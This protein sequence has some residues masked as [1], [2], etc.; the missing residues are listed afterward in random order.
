MNIAHL[1]IGFAPFLPMIWII[2]LAILALGICFYYWRKNGRAP[3]LRLLFFII[4]L[5]T[6]SNPSQNQQITN[7]EPDVVAI[8]VD[9]SSSMQSSAR[10]NGT[11]IALMLLENE[12]GKI[13]NVIIRKT[14]ISDSDDGTRINEAIN[15]A[16]SGFPKDRIAGVIYVGDGLILDNAEIARDYPIHQILIGE[17]QEKDRYIILTN[18]PPAADVGSEAEITF[19]VIENQPID[20]TA[21][22]RVKIGMEDFA[23]IDA[24]INQETKIKIPITSR[25][26]IP[27][28]FELSAL[29]GEISKDNNIITTQIEGTQNRL[30]VLLVTGSPYEGARAWRN[31]LKSDPNVD[32]VHFTILRNSQSE[33]VGSVDELSLIPFPTD[34]LFLNKLNSFDLIV[35]D[36]FKRIDILPDV[37]LEQVANWVENGGAFLML[38]GPA[39]A[40]NDGILT[41]PLARIMPFSAPQGMDEALF[42]PQLTNIGQ[43]H[44]IS[45][46]FYE[47]QKS[48]GRWN[49][50]LRA[51]PNGEVLLSANASPLMITKEVGKGRV[52][53]ILSDR[54]WLWQRG[55]ETGGPFRELMGRTAHWLMKDPQLEAKNLEAS[56]DGKKIVFDIYGNNPAPKIEIQNPNGG[57]IT[58]ALK[59]ID[60]F[61]WQ[62]EYEAP[63]N[64]LYILSY[65]QNII[66]AQIGGGIE[67]N[68][69]DL[70]ANQLPII[71]ATKLKSAG[72]FAFIGIDGKGVLPQF[73]QYQAGGINI[74]LHSFGL[75]KNNYHAGLS[76]RKLPL[77]PPEYFAAIIAAFAIFLWYRE[78]QKR[79]Q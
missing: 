10:V 67:V 24:K 53:A 25:A 28:S 69:Q 47:A 36:R 38:A 33:D 73:T 63:Q 59:Q 68:G 58:P 20:K 15:R 13:P 6:L 9:V 12:I 26:K 35:F 78:G 43:N 75:R 57:T 1:D 74:G 70:R 3:I 2:I 55:F 62:G 48:W 17:R 54:S 19:K 34:E 49:H 72:N 42:S 51:S 76:S 37:Y 61:H 52:C 44:P 46:P 21:I 23:T 14:E 8:L 32:L 64:G 5:I 66:Y 29:N 60:N 77:I 65:D 39:E 11:Q 22:V 40:N 79:G 31:L 45:R 16:T 56:V 30:R 27:I 41:T 71:N 4:I 7:P 50:L 18:S